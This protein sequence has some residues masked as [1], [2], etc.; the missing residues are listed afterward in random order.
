MW[1][2]LKYVYNIKAVSRWGRQ[3]DLHPLRSRQP[4]FA[5]ST[6]IRLFKYVHLFLLLLP[7][8]VL[9]THTDTYSRDEFPYSMLFKPIEHDIFP[10]YYS[11]VSLLNFGNESNMVWILFCTVKSLYIWIACDLI[12]SCSVI[13]VIIKLTKQ[14][15]LH[16]LMKIFSPGHKVQFPLDSMFWNNV[17]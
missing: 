3:M 15:A 9:V 12:I 4:S 2:I 8:L 1:Y 6:H 14:T 10:I 13:K 17:T 7:G 11:V 16:I 5:T